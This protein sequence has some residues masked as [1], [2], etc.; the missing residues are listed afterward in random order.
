MIVPKIKLVKSPPSAASQIKQINFGTAV[1]ITRTLQAAQKAVP[2]E[3]QKDFTYRNRW[4][5]S[6]NPFSIQITRAEAKDNPP[7]GSIQTRAGWLAKQKIGGEVQAGQRRRTF[8]YT[9]D[10]KEYIAIPSKELRPRG[11]TKV[12]S[13]RY[14]PS[15]L[16][17]AFVIKAKDG[18]LMLAV[19]FKSGR[20]FSDISI[21]YILVP[22]I[23]VKKKDAFTPPIEKVVAAQ[24]GPNIGSEIEKALRTA[25]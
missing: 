6:G 7:T 21:M 12:L 20:D 10:G 25:K 16:K 15:N 4:L 2:A 17:N 9:Y 13:Q 11:S 8:P 19:R 18:T 24:L 23:E 22:N 14:W 5:G 3:V 1:G